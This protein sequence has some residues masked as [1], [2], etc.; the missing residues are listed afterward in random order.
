MDQMPN[1]S[2]QQFFLLDAGSR[3]SQ[4]FRVYNW[5]GTYADSIAGTLIETVTAS[6]IQE[7][8]AALLGVTDENLRKKMR[9]IPQLQA[10]GS[11]ALIRVK[12]T[13]KVDIQPVPPQW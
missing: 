6:E 8:A 1:P 3:T 2:V 9:L 4:E 10:F 11:P 5:L 7:R 13:G 12:V